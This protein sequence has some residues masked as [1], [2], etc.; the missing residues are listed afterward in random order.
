MNRQK[1]AGLITAT[2]LLPLLGGTAQA[3]YHADS[4]TG[5]DAL[6]YIEDNHR[7][8]R[9]NRLTAEQ[10]K[11]LADAKAMESKLRYPLDPKKAVPVA[12]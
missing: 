4:D 10:E 11:L 8:E 1:L 5:I 12:F 6:D 9:A 2:L 3:N 7:Q